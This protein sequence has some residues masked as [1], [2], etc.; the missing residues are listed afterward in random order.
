MSKMKIAIINAMD[1]M[2]WMTSQEIA[3]L[4]GLQKRSVSSK[5]GSMALAGDII[6]KDTKNYFGYSLYKIARGKAG[7]GVSSK[8]A[9]LDTHLK[10]A[11]AAQ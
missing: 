4:T 5:I 2:V 6:K 10:R 3:K 1:G 11:R 7:F 8:I 9:L